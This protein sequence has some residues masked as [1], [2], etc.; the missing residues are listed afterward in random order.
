MISVFEAADLG[1][2]KG[3]KGCTCDSCLGGKGDG[4]GGCAAVRKAAAASHKNVFYDNDFSYLCNSG[5]CDTYLGDRFKRLAVG[6]CWTVDVG[7]QYRMRF[8]NEQNINNLNIPNFL[9]LTGDDDNFLLQ[10]TRLYLNA[11]YGSHFRFYGEMLDAVSEFGSGPPRVI[12]ENRT[13]LQNLFIEFRKLDVG[14]GTV[15][16]RVGRQEIQ[17]GAQ[18]MVSPLDWANTRRTFEGAR[19]MWEG[20]SWDIDGFWLRPMTQDAA[21]FKALDSPDLDRQLYGVYG[22]YKDLCRDNLEAYWLAFDSKD[23]TVANGTFRYDTLGTRYWGAEG[24]WLYELEAA[25]QFGTN[26]DDS[27]HSA[28]AVTAGLGR[29]FPCTVFSPTLWGYYD[30]ASGDNT[31]GNGYHHYFPL[32][33]KYNG[34]MDIF[35]R[36]NIHDINLLLTADLTDKVK[37]LAWYHYFMLANGN[38]VPYNVDM[39]NFNGQAAG[40]SGSRDLGH[41]IDFLITHNISPRMSMLYGYSHFFAGNYYA[42]T[43]GVP[44]NGD[45]DF[46]YVQFQLDF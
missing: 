8:H 37:F 28:G 32:A 43:A 18:R 44:Y 36:R 40:T 42:T 6:N 33:H 10:R 9:G 13:E 11:E 14:A 26:S 24:N 38:D 22:T 41:E 1:D 2:T 25:V 39:T 27:A 7:G 21:H 31:V 3:G 35:G 15:G 16:A 34:F 4:K 17:L 19:V 5:C 45:A 46:A 20:E 29:K 30:W 12:E 23:T